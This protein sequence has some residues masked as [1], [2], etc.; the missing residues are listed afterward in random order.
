MIH[1]CAADVTVPPNAQI[2]FEQMFSVVSF[3]P[4][5]IKKQIVNFYNLE[6]SQE[7]ETDGNFAQLGY[8]SSYVLVN[9]G[10]L[11]LIVIV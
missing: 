2:F 4:L 5:D 10:S 1:I 9:L 6:M 11:Q 8:E 3:D 7:V